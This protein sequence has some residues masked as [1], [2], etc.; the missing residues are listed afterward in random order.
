[1]SGI[2][3]RDSSPCSCPIWGALKQESFAFRREKFKQHTSS[4]LKTD[5]EDVVAVHGHD[6]C[7]TSVVCMFVFPVFPAGVFNVKEVAPVPFNT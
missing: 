4:V 5:N 6:P 2:P 7:V 3:V 1:L